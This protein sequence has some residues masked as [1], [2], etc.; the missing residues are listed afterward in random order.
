MTLSE[1][2][3]TDMDCTLHAS[4]KSIGIDTNIYY[5]KTASS[6]AVALTS[7]ALTVTSPSQ[8]APTSSPPVIS[9]PKQEFLA[10][11]YNNNL[12]LQPPRLLSYFPSCFYIIFCIGYR[13]IAHV[14]LAQ[15]NPFGNR[16]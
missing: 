1:T 7:E 14:V 11:C 4:S 3:L 2:V 8:P 10:G 15:F 16:R 13:G 12:K 9:V 6:Q 5:L